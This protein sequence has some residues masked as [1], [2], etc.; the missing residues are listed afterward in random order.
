[1]KWSVKIFDFYIDASI[2]VALAVVALLLATCIFL[3]ITADRNLILFVF[4]ATL[5]CYNFLKYVDWQKNITISVFREK[6]GVAIL[7]LT[8]IALA[9]Y[10]LLLLSTEIWVVTGLML[11][12]IAFYMLPLFP[13]EKNL[14]SLG[15]V[16]VILVAVIWST[17]TVVLPLLNADAPLNTDALILFLQRFMIVIALIIPFEIRDMH[18]DPPGIKTLPRRLGIQKT[19]QLGI[20]LVCIAF[21]LGNFRSDVQY[22]ETITRLV[23][24]VLLSWVI[25]KTPN[26]P[27]KYYASF[28]VEIQPLIWLGVLWLLESFI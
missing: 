21:V 13:R 10:F 15:V 17:V 5:G 11:V 23:V 14:R 18:Y 25:V 4:L 28:W 20:L 27:V 2:H 6:T 12:L 26:K 16:K 9:G 22:S 24:L 8:S 19:K 7:S 1:M 3:N